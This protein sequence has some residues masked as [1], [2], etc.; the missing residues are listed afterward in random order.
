MRGKPGENYFAGKVMGK[1]FD[2]VFASL[3]TN[4]WLSYDEAK[5]LWRYARIAKGPIL[6]VGCYH[7]RST[8]LLA[9]LGWRVYTVDSFAGF[10]SQDPTGSS[11]EAGFRLNLASRGITNVLLFREKIEDWEPRPVGFAYLDGDH[12]YLGTLAQIEKAL[13]CG[14]LAIALHDVNDKGDGRE[15][16]RAALERL[17]MWRERI[18]RLAVWLV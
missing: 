14:P 6:E 1:H 8:V 13:P 9:A 11:V 3:P 18:E 5:C 15:V 16:K 10:D 12:T 17:G 7:G 4:G 2:R